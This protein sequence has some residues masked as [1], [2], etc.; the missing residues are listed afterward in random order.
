MPTRPKTQS[1]LPTS[2][3]GAT[4]LWLRHDLRLHDHPTLHAALRH[5]EAHS[6]RLLIVWFFESRWGESDRFG[7]LRLGARR[8]RF[9][10]ES[11]SELRSALR[12]RG[13]DLLTLEG[14]PTMSLPQLVDLCKA[15]AV[16]TSA[17]VAHEETEQERAL[18]KALGARSVELKT[19]W[20]HT[21]LRYDQLP[22]ALAEL[23]DVFTQFRKRI[24]RHV[25]IDEPLTAPARLPEP[26]RAELSGRAVWRDQLDT[27]SA[28]HLNINLTDD[29][30][31]AITPRGGESAGLERV[32]SYLWESRCVER[33][34]ETR[35]G[36]I[37][38]D[39]STKLSPWLAAGALSPRLIWAEVLR[40]E[41]ERVENSST[42]WVRFEL[43][44][45]EYFQWVA[46]LYGSHIFRRAGLTAPLGRAYQARGQANRHRFERW[47]QAATGDDFVDANMRELNA[48]GWMSNRGRQNVASYLVHELGL[49]WRMGAGYFERE[50]LDYDPASNW[51]NWMYLAG[52]GN[53]PRPQ[54]KFNTRRQAERY[55]PQGEFQSLWSS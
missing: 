23:P 9:L 26:P 34:K 7:T 35:N 16:F 24:E 42:Y 14:D 37:G 39:Y 1:S 8:A 2:S 36:L 17:H 10:I 19:I 31:A 4:I 12:E 13:S 49:D 18:S 21:L 55:D 3:R 48:T 38:A 15:S 33:Y 25:M 5:A 46:A 27:L 50:L 11:A 45:R 20:S 41:R 22:F 47:C 28:R 54:R 30:R 6:T 53:D 29:P 40:Y 43:L 52:V 51:G 32:R 44:W